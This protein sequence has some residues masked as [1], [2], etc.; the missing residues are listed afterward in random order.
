MAIITEG[1]EDESGAVRP[2]ALKEGPWETEV[3]GDGEVRSL[4]RA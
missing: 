2:S 1:K 3:E 4:S